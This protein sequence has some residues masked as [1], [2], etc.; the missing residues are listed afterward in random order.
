MV[1]TKIFRIIIVLESLDQTI[2]IIFRYSRGYFVNFPLTISP[3]HKFDFKILKFLRVG[4]GTH[5]LDTNVILDNRYFH[6]GQ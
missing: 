4:E 6:N 5:G 1:T 2:I 3:I